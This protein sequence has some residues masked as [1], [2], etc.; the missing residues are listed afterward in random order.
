MSSTLLY[1]V[2]PLIIVAFALVFIAIFGNRGKSKDKSAKGKQKVKD[3]GTILKEANRRLSQNPR[4]AEALKMLGDVY[5]QEED[6]DKALKTFGVLVDLCATNKDL[7]E[8]EITLKYAI[9]ALRTKHH[10]EAYK[11][12]VIAR[13]LNADGF[14]VN[15]NLGYLEY[16]RKNYDKAAALLQNA[17]KHQPEHPPNL[18]YLGLSLYKQKRYQEA[19]THLRRTL[20]LDPEDKEA[21]F[22]LGQSYYETG[23]NDK[24]VQILTHLRADPE[25]GPNA[26]LYAGTLHLKTRQYDQALMDFQIGLKHQNIKEDIELELKYRLAMTNIQMQNLTDAIGTLEEIY[27]KRPNFRDVSAQIGK[28]RELSLNSHLQTYLMGSTSEFVALC[29]KLCTMFF[30]KAKVKIVDVSVEKTEYADILAEVST[31]RW[32][33]IVLYRFVRSSGQIGDLTLRDMNARIKDVRAG[34]GFCVSAGEFS[35]TSKQYVEARLIDLIPK[36]RLDKMLNKLSS[37]SSTA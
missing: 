23:Q 13:S 25:L 35:E 26:A 36:G 28:Y 2:P 14:E 32:E 16:L 24:A 4:D 21:L 34:R 11:S 12:L 31:A 29:R 37:W 18:K 6:F 20:D 9:S 30:P 22:A 10:K 8:F 27:R 5:Y 33:D 17:M 7:D 15:H 3:R 19:T 1:I